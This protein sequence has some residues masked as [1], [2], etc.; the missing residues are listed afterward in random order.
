MKRN[1]AELEHAS[2]L[3]D[4][5]VERLQDERAREVDRSVR[6][7]EDPHTLRFAVERIFERPITGE[8]ERLFRLLEGSTQPITVREIE[9]LDLAAAAARGKARS[10]ANGYPTDD[11]VDIVFG[12]MDTFSEEFRS[13]ASS[14]RGPSTLLKRAIMEA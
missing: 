2:R 9:K 8:V 5:V 14:W 10:A 12:L 6:T 11:V 13:I 7:I 4:G 1:L 3:L